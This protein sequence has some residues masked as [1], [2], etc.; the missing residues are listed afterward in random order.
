[1][2]NIKKILKSNFEIFEMKTFLKLLI[3]KIEIPEN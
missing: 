1:M 3:D 2:Q